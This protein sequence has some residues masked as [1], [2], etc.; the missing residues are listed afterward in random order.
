MGIFD[1][2]ISYTNIYH[3][4]VRM[5]KMN[6][7]AVYS[8]LDMTTRIILCTTPNTCRQS[9]FSNRI[10]GHSHSYTIKD[11]IR[12]LSVTKFDLGQN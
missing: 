7:M 2:K 4:Y 6:I 11:A 5:L 9:G 3:L 8:Q 1:I 12:V 10:V